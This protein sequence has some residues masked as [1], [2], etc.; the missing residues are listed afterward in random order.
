MRRA[1]GLQR[2]TLL[3]SLCL[4]GILLTAL[5]LLLSYERNNRHEVL[6]ISR[7]SQTELV[8]DVTYNYAAAITAQLADAVT[9]DL[10]YFD[11]E[12]VGRQLAFVKQ[13]PWA[14]D[15][16]VYDA[17]GLI[18]HDGSRDISAYGVAVG[19]PVAQGALS[20]DET[21]TAAGDARMEAAKRI[22][23]GD[24]ILGGVLTRFDLEQLNDAIA[25]GNEQL[26]GRLE[27]STWWRLLSLSVL[28]GGMALLGLLASWATQRTIVRPILKLAAAARQ[29]EAGD[30][31]SR[32]L[33]SGRRDEIGD[34]ERAF[35]QM[36]TRVAEAHRTSERKAYVDPLTGLP[37]RRAF[38]ETIAS[39]MHADTHKEFA[40][41]F[42]DVDNL[43]LINDRLGHEAGDSALIA[44]AH[45]ANRIVYRESAGTAWLA[46][47]GGDE[48]A[49]LCEGRPLEPA[50]LDLA[51]AIVTHWQEHDQTSVEKL[52][53]SIGIATY[54]AHATMTSDLLKCADTAMY[55]AKSA[56][57]NRIQLHKPGS[58]GP[59][60]PSRSSSR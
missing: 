47:I 1:W 60:T 16:I 6:R 9:N 51:E 57:K 5:V 19:T 2:K 32:R 8:S 41:M 55:R 37:N 25:K 34:L 11:L 12:S 36:S 52:T 24:Q 59:N 53:V 39:W 38:D 40:L 21:R 43:K 56:G 13:L 26:A 20:G 27:E 54:P 45:G 10:Y 28:L 17:R 42:V 35:E 31:R 4:I 50:A 18:V 15:A 7:Q 33:D 3:V 58:N 29:I 22:R 49:V 14:I 48:F 44:F 30:Y 23:V 46:R